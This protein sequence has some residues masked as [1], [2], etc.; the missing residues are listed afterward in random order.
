MLWHMS[1]SAC[2]ELPAQ[3]A[4]RQPAGLQ[5][6]NRP[7][8]LRTHCSSFP[9][10]FLA[11]GAL[12]II[13][14]QSFQLIV[15]PNG[16]SAIN[17]EHSWG[18]GVAV[19]RYFDEI[20][21]ES[22]ATPTPEAVAPLQPLK[23]SPLTGCRSLDAY[24]GCF[25]SHKSFPSSLLQ[26]SPAAPHTA[27]DSTRTPRL[28]SWIQHC[29]YIASLFT[30]ALLPWCVV[31]AIHCHRS[32]SVAAHVQALPWALSAQT[33]QDI[34]N[35]GVSFDRHRESVD[36]RVIQTDVLTTK[37]LKG[38]D[39]GVDG[40]SR[41]VRLPSLLPTSVCCGCVASHHC[42][43]PLCAPHLFP[44]PPTAR[45]RHPLPSPTIPLPAPLLP[46]PSRSCHADVVPAGPLS[47]VW[48]QR[49]GTVL[50]DWH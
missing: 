5:S 38:L 50:E 4:K 33:L 45:C 1:E 3:R 36:Q 31:S 28:L 46:L 48:A 23:V 13:C 18:D 7:S 30:P 37:I 42:G 21:Q 19:L 17:F 39:L 35:A 44:P 8:E 26:S 2:S 22:V 47:H 24:L 40:A 20:Y 34:A 9:S 14:A 41:V 43:G 10:L 32:L 25:P 29:K 11:T 16:K 27:V 12:P 6:E 15:C 49:C